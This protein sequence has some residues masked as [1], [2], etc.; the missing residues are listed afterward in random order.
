MTNKE[1]EYVADNEIPDD[2]E[3]SMS[4]KKIADDAWDKFIQQ[5]DALSTIQ[6]TG[7]AFSAV[8]ISS[9]D[10]ETNEQNVVTQINSLNAIQVGD[11]ALAQ[12]LVLH[13]ATE[14]IKRS[15]QFLEETGQIEP[16]ES[17]ELQRGLAFLA[18]KKFIDAFE[19]QD[20]NIDLNSLKQSYDTVL[21]KPE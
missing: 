19:L 4:E 11:R 5:I 16:A 12:D 6:A 2:L 14:N 15:V 9:H 1:K 17:A 21:A 13:Y 10:F 8:L 20:E 7:E 3:E 18:I